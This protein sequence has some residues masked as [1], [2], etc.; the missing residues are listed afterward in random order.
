MLG[1]S[2][3]SLYYKAGLAVGEVSPGLRLVFLSLQSCSC[4]AEMHRYGNLCCRDKSEEATKQIKELFYQS[5]QKHPFSVLIFPESGVI[6]SI[7]LSSK[8]DS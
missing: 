5:K 8:N 7:L 1:K 2:S 4:L 3:T 6:I